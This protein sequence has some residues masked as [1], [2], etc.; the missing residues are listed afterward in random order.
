MMQDDRPVSAVQTKWVEFSKM[1][2]RIIGRVV[3]E[4]LAHGIEIIPCYY[5]ASSI[6]S[7]SIGLSGQCRPAGPSLFDL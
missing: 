4:E 6:D 5:L 3:P 2:T 7:R 1:G